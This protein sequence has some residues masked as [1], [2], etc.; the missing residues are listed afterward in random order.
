VLADILLLPAFR[1][2]ITTLV[3][4]FAAWFVAWLATISR[5]ALREGLKPSG[6]VLVQKV[7]DISL[8]ARLA[9]GY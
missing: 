2:I 8:K 5:A 6:T 7:G 1:K 3:S 9:G 4:V